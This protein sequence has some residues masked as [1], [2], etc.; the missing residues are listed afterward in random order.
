MNKSWHKPGVFW[1]KTS[2]NE[3]N[4][5]IFRIFAIF[6]DLNTIKKW[7]KLPK[8]AIYG[9]FLTSFYTNFERGIKG[10]PDT[11]RASLYTSNATIC[12]L[13]WRE[14]AWNQ[15]DLIKRSNK[16]PK[17]A[18]FRQF[19]GHFWPFLQFSSPKILQIDS[20]CQ[21]IVQRC[22]NWTILHQVISTF[23]WLWS[24]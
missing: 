6:Y 19:L 7:L 14:I 18:I 11:Y 3:K 24:M 10:H 15:K 13:L 9:H 23:I 22:Y 16:W 17:L 4:W 2:K 8:M 21:K 12:S 1:Y 20:C 5:I